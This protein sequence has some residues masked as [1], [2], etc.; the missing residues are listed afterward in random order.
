MTEDRIQR[1]EA[2]R[3]RTE[4]RG[5]EIRRAEEQKGRWPRRETIGETSEPCVWECEA[6]DNNPPDREMRHLFQLSKPKL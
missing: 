1:S 3:Q 2:R 6:L 5:Q 4:G